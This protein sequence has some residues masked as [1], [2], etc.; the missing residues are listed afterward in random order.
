MTLPASSSTDEVT[1]RHLRVPPL[2]SSVRTRI[3]PAPSGDL[4]VGNV[5]TALY[6]WALARRHGGHFVL[7]IE[8]TDR[9]RV[10]EAAVAGVAE[11]LRWAGLDWDEGPGIGGPYAPYRQSER[12]EY[13]REATDR[14]ISGGN[15]YPC[16]CTAEEVARRRAAG[17][18]TG[19]RPS[20]YDGFCRTLD[21]T[22]RRRRLAAGQQ[23]VLRFA[24]P[25][26]ET[27]WLDQV[28]GEVT[29]RHAEIPDFALTRADG[30]PLYMLA[31]AVDDMAMGLTHIVRGEDLTTA[32][33]RQLALYAALGHPPERWP[34]FAHLPLLVGAD[35]KPLS[36]RNGEVALAW[37]RQAG[38]LPEALRNYLSLLGWS[39]PDGREVFTTDEMVAAFSLERVSR[40]PARFDTRKLEAINGDW[41]RAVSV[42]ELV[43]RVSPLLQAAGL[44]A[45]PAL[46]AAALPLAQERMSRLDQAPG[47]LGFLLVADEDFVVEEPG[48]PAEAGPALAA[49]E[50]ALASLA[51][52]EWRAE[53]IEEA[54][55]STLV[56]G[57][58][59]AP[60]R[61]FQPIRL[62]VTGRLVSPPLFESLEL[63][64]R[65]RTLARIA[66]AA[67]TVAAGS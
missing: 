26:G 55:R 35:G 45:D 13:Y 27:T 56:A 42:P 17:P 59:L 29:I 61:A 2:D 4:H 51:E 22:D 41:I 67:G 50:Q 20:G 25:A 60:R 6:S 57:L 36:K 11:A 31:A 23:P 66:A 24:M 7:R 44:D 5:R 46:L 9:T 28:R 40:N 18:A 12:G 49:A 16:F 32:T 62:A 3:A 30:A 15:A 19:G 14:L 48:L 8:D 21:D 52:P 1:R 37:Y 64:G 54:L 58:G 43:N 53:R 38:F 47:M 33:P 39:M 10:S 63:L 65:S 34:A